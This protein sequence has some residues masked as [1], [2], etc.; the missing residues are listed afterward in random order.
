MHDMPGM[1]AEG[2]TGLLWLVY[3][4]SLVIAALGYL[5]AA[6]LIHRRGDRWPVRRTLS[7]CAGLL[8]AAIAVSGGGRS[9]FTAHMTDHLLLGMAA[10][11]LLVLA[12]PITLGLRALPVARARRLSRFLKTWPLRFLTY[13]V[14]AAVLDAGGLWALYTTGIY[15]RMTDHAWLHVL[16]SVHTLVAGYLFTAAVI[17]VDPAPHRPGPRFRSLVLITFLAAHDILAKFLYAHPPAGVAVAQAQ[18][19]AQLMYY[20]GDLLDLL[21]ITILCRQ[22]YTAAA[23]ESSRAQRRAWRLPA[24]M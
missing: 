22:W 11:V 7:W 24:D 5:G 6:R 13:P 2:S 9:D 14:T 21:L 23:P 12:A 4:P 17:G 16:V 19:G 8:A 10:P 3:A 20:G 18:A 15:S 1:D